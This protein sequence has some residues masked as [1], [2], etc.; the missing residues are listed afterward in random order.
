MRV[1]QGKRLIEYNRRKKEELKHLNE[2]IA[3]Q[4]D[5]IECKPEE[6]SN[7]YLYTISVSVVELVNSWM[8]IFCARGSLGHVLDVGIRCFRAISIGIKWSS[9]VKAHFEGTKYSRIEKHSVLYRSPL[10]P[11]L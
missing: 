10:G 2:Q 8:D 1:E 3:K 11:F 4:D 9:P 7:N 6:P 5:M